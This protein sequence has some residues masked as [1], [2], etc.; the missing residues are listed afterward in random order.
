MMTTLER[1]EKILLVNRKMKNQI[2]RYHQLPSTLVPLLWMLTYCG[3]HDHFTMC[4][5][6]YQV[7]MMYTL[8]QYNVMY[9]LYLHKTGKKLVLLTVFQSTFNRLVMCEKYIQIHAVKLFR[10]N[11]FSFI[12]SNT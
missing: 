8:D 3:D 5:Y 10:Y 1:L 4:T 6:I 9:Q 2:K 11:A 12:Y 7:I